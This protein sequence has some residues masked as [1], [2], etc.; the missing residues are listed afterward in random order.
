MSSRM[1]PLEKIQHYAGRVHLFETKNNFSIGKYT[2]SEWL[3]LLIVGLVFAYILPQL[4]SGE[5]IVNAIIVLAVLY[6]IYYLFCFLLAG[7]RGRIVDV[8]N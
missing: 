8:M 1:T 7:G 6:A 3:F 2:F 5:L 4:L